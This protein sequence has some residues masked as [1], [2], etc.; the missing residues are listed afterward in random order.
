VNDKVTRDPSETFAE[1][2]AN[3]VRS[4]RIF[5]NYR[6]EDSSGHAGRLYDDLAERFD[7]SEVFIDIDKIEPGLD[8]VE[9]IERA[10]EGCDVVLALIGKHW[11]TITD[12]RGERRID[13]P[14]D[15]VRLELEAALARGTRVIPVCVQGSEMPNSLDLPESLRGLAR[16]HAIDLS[17]KRWRHDVESLA[18]V[19]DR[20]A[21]DRAERERLEREGA[22][23]D[24]LVQEAAERERLAQLAAERERL[25]QEAA[26]REEHE[27]ERV[28]R[29]RLEQDAAERERVAQET[30]ERERLAREAAERERLAE[31]A[32]ERERLQKE[33]AERDRAERAREAE[34]RRNERVGGAPLAGGAAATVEEV[35]DVGVGDR[36]AG[37]TRDRVVAGAEARRR[38]VMVGAVGG[39]LLVAGVTAVVVLRG[40]GDDPPSPDATMPTVVSRPAI[41][42]TARAGSTLTASRGSWSSAPTRFA[43]RWQRCDGSGGSCSAIRGA[44]RRTYAISGA[45]VGGRVRV[46]VSA[47]NAEGSGSSRSNATRVVAPALVAP[48]NAEPPG[49]SGTLR[50]GLMVSATPGAWNGS[51]PIRVTRSWLRCDTAGDCV[52]IGGADGA[53][54]TLGSSDVGHRLRVVEKASNKAGTATVRSTASAIVAALPQAPDPEPPVT[55]TE[56]EPVCPPDCPTPP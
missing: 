14:D 27:R 48:K 34:Q 52:Q 18:S 29:E 21:T 46:V 44:T 1:E 16:R 47:T 33:A 25:A 51:K 7:E 35:P 15:Y 23:S 12:A 2:G 20:L 22:E 40:G 6:R 55:T 24:R 45:D 50:E 28:E 5:L 26:E 30:A 31:Q 41:S 56:P 32:A 19:L 43:Y 9:A 4:L 38:R 36:Q 54:Y 42:G 11:L 39:V 3:G 49:I 37:G 53:T 10:L 13:S 17:D 8:F